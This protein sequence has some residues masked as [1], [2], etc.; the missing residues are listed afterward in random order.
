MTGG[1]CTHMY[2]LYCTDMPVL[3]QTEPKTFSASASRSTGVTVHTHAHAAANRAKTPSASAEAGSW[4]TVFAT[5]TALSF[6]LMLRVC[7]SAAHTLTHTI[8]S[9]SELQQSPGGQYSRPRLQDD[10]VHSLM[11]SALCLPCVRLACRRQE[12]IIVIGGGV[13]LDVTGLAANLYRRN[14]CIIKVCDV[15]LPVTAVCASY[16]QAT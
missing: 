7:D 14:T 5:V 11:C 4:P 13:C 10:P 2:R 1:N 3:L 6:K 16:T 9:T 8:P 15:V 12:P